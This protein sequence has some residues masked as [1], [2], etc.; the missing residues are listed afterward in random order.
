MDDELKAVALVLI[1]L[2]GAVAVYP[3]LAESRVVEPF[4]ELGVLGPNMKI[5]DYPRQ[6]VV[7][8][9]FSLY[10]YVGNHEGSSQY[11]RVFAKLG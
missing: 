2:M 9:R 8:Q 10:I 7:G 4:S 1:G 5:G 3:I 11:Y 6:L